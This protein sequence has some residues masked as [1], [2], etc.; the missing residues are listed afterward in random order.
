VSCEYS[1][2]QSD[3]LNTSSGTDS[4]SVDHEIRC[5]INPIIII[6]TTT[7]FNSLLFMCRANSH[8]A[9]YRHS[10]V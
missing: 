1:I 10:T 2:Q 3:S 7:E 4:L 8:K 6:I 9:S 5:I